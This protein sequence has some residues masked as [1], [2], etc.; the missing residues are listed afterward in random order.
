MSLELP[1]WVPS[2]RR[3]LPP[4]PEL[5]MINLWI[6]RLSHSVL[7]RVQLK[8]SQG[9]H[10]FQAPQKASHTITWVTMDRDIKLSIISILIISQPMVLDYLTQHLKGES[11]EPCAPHKGARSFAPISIDWN[12]L[13]TKEPNWWNTAHPLNPKSCSQSK[14][15][16]W[17]MIS[18][19]IFLKTLMCA[20]YYGAIMK[21]WIFLLSGTGIN[22][23]IIIYEGNVT[24][25]AAYYITPWNPKNFPVGEDV[26]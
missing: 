19:V 21:S 24:N 26:S 15:I 7:Q 3:G 5:K 14:R 8:T 20:E 23:L 17:S 11:S 4:Y 2:L 1:S 18:K 13:Q 22:E 10:D 6:P 25:H 9:F 12:C 16:L